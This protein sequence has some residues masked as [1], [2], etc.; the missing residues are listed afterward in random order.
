MEIYDY[1]EAVSRALLRMVKKN[2]YNYVGLSEDALRDRIGDD[3]WI[4]DSVTGNGSGYYSGKDS[5]YDK[6]LYGNIELLGEALE[7]FDSGPDFLK[8]YGALGCDV[9]IRCYLIP[10]CMNEAVEYVENYEKSQV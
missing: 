9:Y 10:Q 6:N 8:N 5:N 3:A 2:I 4:D 7:E 1:R